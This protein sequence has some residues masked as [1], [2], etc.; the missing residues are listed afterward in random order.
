M[1][2]DPRGQETKEWLAIARTDLDA[3]KSLATHEEFSSQASFHAQQSAE[4]TIKAFLVWHQ[5]RFKKDHDIRYLGDLALKKDPTLAELI[6]EAVC[7]NPYAVTTRYPGFSD[8]IEESEVQIAI[9]IA[10][11]VF[12][13]ILSR[14]P[15]EVHP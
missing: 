13:E 11:K 4:K 15:R 2:L 10:E 3:G 8:E 1:P 7:L 12:S 14:L 9:S 6:D 5:E